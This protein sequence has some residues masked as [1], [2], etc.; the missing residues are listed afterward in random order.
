MVIT[1]NKV[2]ETGTVRMMVRNGVKHFD[3]IE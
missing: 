2:T 1:M 3:V